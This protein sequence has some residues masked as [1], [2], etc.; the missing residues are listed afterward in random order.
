M[1]AISLN[2]Q[3]AGLLTPHSIRCHQLRVD[4]STLARHAPA[5]STQSNIL[6]PCPRHLYGPLLPISLRQTD[7]TLVLESLLYN[8][9]HSPYNLPQCRLH[10]LA[11]PFVINPFLH[12]LNIT[13]FH[14]TTYDSCS[15]SIDP[16]DARLACP[17]RVS[18]S[19]LLLRAALLAYLCNN[20]S[21]KHGFHTRKKFAIYR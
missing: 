14:H 10:C 15:S 9:L 16:I 8:S 5:H 19:S 4:K 18:L 7:H 13:F 1:S 11:D 6:M 3:H 21:R 20:I 17:V 12:R 2:C